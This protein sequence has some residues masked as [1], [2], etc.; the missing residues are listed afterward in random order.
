M[1]INNLEHFYLY[2][3]HNRQN[4]NLLFCFSEFG[5]VYRRFFLKKRKKNWILMNEFT[6]RSIPVKTRVEHSVQISPCLNNAWPLT[7]LCVSDGGPIVSPARQHQGAWGQ[8][9]IKGQR[10]VQQWHCETKAREE[11]YSCRNRSC[12]SVSF[13]LLQRRP[14]ISF[15]CLHSGG[16]SPQSQRN[17]ET[18]YEGLKG[19]KREKEK[20]RKRQ[21]ERKTERQKK[22]WKRRKEGR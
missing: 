3:C 18:K 19:R 2:L 17:E 14:V 5:F 12:L 10:S 6:L 11:C 22:K 9:P 7:S 8:W 4:H 15:T 1:N 16:R 21:T 13:T 20:E